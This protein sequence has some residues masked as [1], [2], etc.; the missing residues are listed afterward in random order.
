M[1]HGK[2]HP[3][4]KVWMETEDGYVFGPGVYSILRK[5]TEV[6]TL[7]EAA[8]E[9]GMSYRYA[10]GLI[11]KAEEKL[12]EPLLVAHK[13]GKAGGGGAE[14]SARGESFL[15]EFK[16]LREQMA[17]ASKIYPKFTSGKVLNVTSTPSGTEITL[18]MDDSVK[19]QIKKGDNVR[20][21]PSD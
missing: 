19:T 1:D 21:G 14:L 8:A 13:G 9:L 17:L 16:N 20:I 6:G 2:P 15:I 5:V 18:R 11:R 10:W 4:F 3:A 7:K 12:G